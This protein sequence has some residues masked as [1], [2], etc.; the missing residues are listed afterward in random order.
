MFDS[1]LEQEQ[2]HPLSV[3][4]NEEFEVRYWTRVLQISRADLRAAV[5][6]VGNSNVY[7][8][9]RH[10]GHELPIG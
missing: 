3:N 2:L 9:A 8:I 7:D 1:R 5:A 4:V 6:A 10:L